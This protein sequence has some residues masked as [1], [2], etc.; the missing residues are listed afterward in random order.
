MPLTPLCCWYLTRVNTVQFDSS[1]KLNWTTQYENTPGTELWWQPWMPLSFGRI[2]DDDDT[3]EYAGFVCVC[4][5]R[6]LKYALYKWV[7]KGFEKLSLYG[8]SLNHEYSGI[9]GFRRVDSPLDVYNSCQNPCDGTSRPCHGLLL[10]MWCSAYCFLT[11]WRSMCDEVSIS[12]AALTA[13]NYPG[14]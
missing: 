7:Q 2:H 10:M 8:S 1:W 6:R 5:K 13:R 11:T 9:W 14:I 12:P 4:W 3:K